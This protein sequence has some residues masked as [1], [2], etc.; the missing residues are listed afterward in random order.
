MKKFLIILFISFTTGVYA[1]GYDSLSNSARISVLTSSPWDGQVF[2]VFGHSAMRIVDPEKG[3]DI[4]FNY[5]IFDFDA[6][7]FIWRFATGKKDYYV[8]Q[9]DFG[10]YIVEYKL[11]GSDV[12]EQIINLTDDE[13]QKIWFYLLNN[14]KPENRVYR[15]N[16]I[17]NN[18][19]TK[20]TEILE[21][22][23][24]GELIYPPNNEP[25]TFRELLSEFTSVKPWLEFGIN[26]I[27]GTNTDKTTTVREQMFLPLYQV[28]TFD[29]TLINRNGETENL[30]LSKTKV[31]SAPPHEIKEPSFWGS[32][33]FAGIL[34]L[35]ITIIISMFDYKLKLFSRIFDF[36]LFFVTGLL[37]CV[38]LFLMCV[39]QPFSFPNLN[40]LWLNPLALILSIALLVRPSSKFTFYYQ[41]V[42]GIIITLF[43]LTFYFLP[44]KIVLV[45]IPFIISIWL[46]TILSVFKNSPNLK[47]VTGK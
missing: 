10:R 19:T 39:D 26:I 16:E 11:R 38:I 42:N 31:I 2:T 28:K 32:P 14:V 43:L 12:Y 35:F 17:F 24:N 9:A 29:H 5:G 37:G 44:Q 33:L 34:L 3:M 13:K 45:F 30:V 7:N 20:L 6:P 47:F 22:N 1:Q 27:F 25:K 4:I 46:R 41:I 18:C 36:L 40:I 23:I 8:Q 21:G 15:Y